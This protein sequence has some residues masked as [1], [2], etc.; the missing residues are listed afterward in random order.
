[1]KKAITVLSIIGCLILS[2]FAASFWLADYDKIYQTFLATAKIDK[3]LVNKANFVV[4]RFPIPQILITEIKQEGKFAV[5][6]V[7]IKLSPLSLVQL[8]PKVSDINASE[9]VI[10]LAHDDVN[11][12]SHDEF[13]GELLRKDMLNIKANIGSL[14]FLES[15]QDEALRIKNFSLDSQNGQVLFGGDISGADKVTGSFKNQEGEVSSLRLGLTSASYNLELEEE[16]KNYALAKGVA[17]L[18]LTNLPNKLSRF[19]PEI[20]ELT[21][22]LNSAEEVKISFDIIPQGKDVV[23]FGQISVDSESLQAKGEAMFSRSGES[24]ESIKLSF[25]K[26]DFQSWGVNKG[27]SA[28]EVSAISAGQKSFGFGKNNFD[29][30]LSAAYIKLNANNIITNAALSAKLDNGVMQLQDFSGEINK[31]GRFK[32]SGDITQNSF[33]SL[34]EGKVVL[35]HNDLNEIAELIAGKEARSNAPL[36]YSLTADLKLSSVD[37]SM[38]NLLIRTADNEISGN[39][40]VKFIGEQ[41]RHNV[42]LKLAKLNLDNKNFPMMFWLYE[43]GSGLLEGTKSQ[44]YLNKFIPLRKINV[45]GNYNINIDS[46]IFAEKEYTNSGFSLSLAPAQAKISNL[47]LKRGDEFI[48]VSVDVL[49]SGIKPIFSIKVNDGAFAVDFLKPNSLLEIRKN[50]LEKHDLSKVEINLD[51]S[52]AKLQQNDVLFEDVRLITKNDSNLFDINKLEA[53]LFGGKL[54][55]TGSILLDPHTINFVYALNSAHVDEVSKV[56]PAGLINSNGAFSSSGMITTSG[57]KPEELLYNLYTK[58]NILGQGLSINNFSIDDLIQKASNYDYEL[59]QLNEDINTALLTG[60][61]EVNNLK[62][63]IELIK[64]IVKIPSITFQTQYASVS[65]AANFNIYDFSLDLNSVFSFYLN[66]SA[67]GRSYQS[68]VPSKIAVKASGDLLSPKKEAEITELH[69]LLQ[70]RRR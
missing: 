41:P 55:A 49:A 40:S 32:L 3:N 28:S 9:V 31:Q 56:L 46:L 64:G 35:T 17:R 26:I 11:L 22:D 10:H 44:D 57:T 42:N 6:D 16:Y 1:M 36:P 61:T 34:F 18:K 2:A 63:N 53:K 52:L 12:L 23:Q 33:R 66:R 8:D 43:S 54:E 15:D 60:K 51:A 62:T 45:L 19:I 25:S 5:K 4:K 21:K 30:N 39:V 37:L 58:S 20:N 50:L 70:T 67:P 65:A 47:H 59:G 7:E 24:A 68:R 69:Q 29:L 14:L 38:Q 27:G 13:I 48:D